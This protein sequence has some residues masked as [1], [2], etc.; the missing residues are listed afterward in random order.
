MRGLAGDLSVLTMASSRYDILLCSETLVSDMSHVSELLVPGFCRPVLL[1]RGRMPLA[2]GMAANVRDGYGA[3]RQ[4]MFKSG[5]CEMLIFRVCEHIYVFSLYNNPDIDDRNF[6]WLLTSMGAVQAEDVHVSFLFVDD[7]NGH[8]QKW[9]GFTATKRQGVAALDFATVSGCDQLVVGPTHSRDGTINLLM[10]YVPDQERVAVE[11]PLGNS[12]RSFLSA[13]ISTA[14]A[15][16]KICVC[17]QVF[18]KHQLNWNQFVVQYWFYPGPI[19]CLLTI[20][21]RF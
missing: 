7:L 14:Q 13:V 21:L 12:H 19:F 9:L 15:V 2:R 8:H 20:L 10:T 1:C 17:W 18:L 6:D 16:P 11:A 5:Y 4:C 3:F